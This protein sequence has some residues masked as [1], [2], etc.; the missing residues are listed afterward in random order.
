MEPNIT[1][2]RFI[3]ATT[4]TAFAAG[5]TSQA[6]PRYSPVGRADAIAPVVFGIGVAAG[7]VGIEYMVRAGIEY[8]T[9]DDTPSADSYGANAF[10]DEAYYRMKSIV[11]SDDTVRTTISNHAGNSKNIAWSKGKVAAIEKINAGATKQDTIDA[12]LAANDAY[13]TKIQKN[14][15]NHYIEQMNKLDYLDEQQETHTGLGNKEVFR[16]EHSNGEYSGQDTL[17]WTSRRQEES[18]TLFDGTSVTGVPYY[19]FPLNNDSDGSKGNWIFHV[20]KL[21]DTGTTDSNFEYARFRC[22]SA[23]HGSIDYWSTT[24]RDVANVEWWFRDVWDLIVQQHT[25]MESNLDQWARDA[26][27]QVA[28]GEIDLSDAVDP[29]TWA[30]EYASASEAPYAYA[31]ADLIAL[32]IDTDAGGEMVIYLHDTD[33]TVTGLLGTSDP[34]T[35]GFKVDKQ[36]SPA[37]FNSPVFMAYDVASGDA[38]LPTSHYNTTIDG[39]VLTFVDEPYNDTIHTVTT[40]YDETVDL[41]AS[42]FTWNDTDSVWEADLSADL[43]NDIADVEK[44]ELEA[45]TDSTETAAMIEVK[46]PFTIK[47]YTTHEGTVEDTVEFQSYNTQTSDVGMTQEE[48]E[49]L[50]DARLEQF[51]DSDP[52]GG[53]GLF[54]QSVAQWARNNPAEAAASGVGGLAVLKFL[55]A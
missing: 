40:S 34:P 20:H 7:L 25:D 10:K 50:L 12:A 33:A 22:H 2:R 1:R 23:N 41:V 16:F 38:I 18:I 24:T 49:Q 55:F 53:G 4:G 39:G 28:A 45:N 17:R 27:S 32:G 52:T 47:R 21:E 46:E 14:L 35:D 3:Q 42:D 51:D 9:G 30:S 54:G 29:V 6:P 37:D 44:I 5:V 48:L 13:Y 15:I 43:E 36:Y 26:Y 31:M 8:V 11:A 19:E